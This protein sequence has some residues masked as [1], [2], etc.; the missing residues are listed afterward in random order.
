MYVNK[1]IGFKINFL[2]QGQ[3][4]SPNVCRSVRVSPL[5]YDA[6]LCAGSFLMV[7]GTLSCSTRNGED[8]L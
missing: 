4:I 8:T 3:D 5:L 7:F 1:T 2:L 6:V